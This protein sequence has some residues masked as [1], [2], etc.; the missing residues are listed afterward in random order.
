[1]LLQVLR[2]SLLVEAFNL[3]AAIEYQLGNLEAGRDALLDMP[4]RAEDELDPV[5]LH[6]HALLNMN[7]DPNNGLKKLNFLLGML[8]MILCLILVF[9]ILIYRGRSTST[10]NIR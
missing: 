4:P 3:K 7:L 6:N 9:L 2:E 1:M 8:M 5:T 10:W